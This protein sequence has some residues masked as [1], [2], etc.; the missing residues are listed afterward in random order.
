MNPRMSLESAACH[1]ADSNGQGDRVLRR[2]EQELGHDRSDEACAGAR[3]PPTR[4][5]DCPEDS[6][7]RS[8]D[9][10]P[11]DATERGSGPPHRRYSGVSQRI[12]NRDL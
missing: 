7:F 10:E 12:R 1:A 11:R 3:Q 9:Q 4:G 8:A 2:S 6:L 5:L